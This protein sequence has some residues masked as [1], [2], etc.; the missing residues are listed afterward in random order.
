MKRLVSPVVCYTLSPPNLRTSSLQG[1]VANEVETEQIV[2]EALT[3]GFYS[4]LSREEREKAGPIGR[5]PSARYTSYLQVGDYFSSFMHQEDVV[6]S[7]LCV[8]VSRKYSYLLDSGYHQHEPSSTHRKYGLI[9]LA[10]REMCELISL[11]LM[12]DKS[13]SWTR[14]TLPPRVILT[15][16][17]NV[18]VR[19]LS[20]LTLSRSVMFHMTVL[21]QLL[22]NYVTVKRAGAARKQAAP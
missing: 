19:Q 21:T 15:I 22:T 18:T 2:S 17:L 9:Q 8:T 16:Y 13:P 10:T 7:S 20:F 12:V 4:P 6:L 1:N 11:L 3:T 5:S 14:I